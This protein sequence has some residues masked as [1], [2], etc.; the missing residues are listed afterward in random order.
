MGFYGCVVVQ[1][2]SGPTAACS[3]PGVGLTVKEKAW[4]QR[5]Q[6]ILMLCHKQAALEDRQNR[7]CTPRLISI[8]LLWYYLQNGIICQRKPAYTHYFSNIASCKRQRQYWSN[9]CQHR[10][11][12]VRWDS[13]QERNPLWCCRG[14]R[15][16][17]AILSRMPAFSLQQDIWSLQRPESAQADILI[18]KLT[19]HA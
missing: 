16:T 10:P 18:I 7:F 12:P 5:K 4:Q 2:G 15:V 19:K 1:A 3:G 11:S 14:K 8:K 13:K 9:I 6:L 17:R